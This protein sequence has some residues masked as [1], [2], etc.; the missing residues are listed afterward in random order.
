MRCQEF[1][2]MN[3]KDVQDTVNVENTKNQY[4]VTIKDSKNNYPRHFVIGNE[5]YDVVKKYVLLR[6]DDMPSDR[7]F[8]SYKNGRCIRQLMGKNKIRMISKTI[9]LYLNL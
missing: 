4:V 5:Y 1:L 7:F 2:N 9:A 8:V 3:S 6:L